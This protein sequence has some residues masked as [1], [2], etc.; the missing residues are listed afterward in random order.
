MNRHRPLVLMMLLTGGLKSF[1][2]ASRSQLFLLFSLLLGF[3]IFSAL[4]STQSQFALIPI[5][6]N[7]ALLAWAVAALR[8]WQCGRARRYL[9]PCVALMVL[10]VVVLVS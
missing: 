4:N 1:R 9:G 10:V 6:R 2:L 3:Q 7:L 8:F 5:A